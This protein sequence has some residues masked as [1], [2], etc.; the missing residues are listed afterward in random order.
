MNLP[1]HVLARIVA[2]SDDPRTLTRISKN[3]ATASM[4]EMKLRKQ[5]LDDTIEIGKSSDVLKNFWMYS[6][7]H[8]Y[9][10]E[11]GAKIILEGIKNGVLLDEVKSLGRDD[12]TGYTVIR[13]DSLVN[14]DN[15][16]MQAL[17]NAS[18]NGSVPII[19]KLLG[20][21]LCDIK[22]NDES[23]WDVHSIV[24]GAIIGNH[25]SVLR[26]FEFPGKLNR[27]MLGSS[28]SLM[29][30]VGKLKEYPVSVTN[31]AKGNHVTLVN[32]YLE[33]PLLQASYPYLASTGYVISENVTELMN[34]LRKFG[35]TDYDSITLGN[36]IPLN[37]LLHGIAASGNLPITKL[38][39]QLVSEDSKEAIRG[40]GIVSGAITNGHI[41]LAEFYLRDGDKISSLLNPYTSNMV[42]P[43]VKN[44]F[45][46]R[47]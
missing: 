38:I 44:Y 43:D 3:Y 22:L 40:N 12:G 17:R 4:I 21:K 23:F 11:S 18:E 31:L 33:P 15:W 9:M 32:E 47:W 25:L 7:L 34:I 24:Q 36:G 26:Y 37:N 19:E 27:S 14:E 46:D 45:S 13:L 28:Y 6:Y 35:Y 1:P 8:P 30:D 20:Y 16:K 2:N 41:R 39:Y 29:G 10:K 5:Q 42:H